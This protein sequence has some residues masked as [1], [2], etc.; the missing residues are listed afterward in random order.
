LFEASGRAGYLAAYHPARAFIVACT[1]RVAK[2]HS[3]VRSEFARLA[4]D[5]P[6]IERRLTSFLA[7]AYNLKV[8]ADYAVGS[9][10]GVSAKEA[11]EAIEGATRFVQAVEKALSGAQ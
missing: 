4:K 8:A 3:G 2:M 9:S 7:R 10:V 11:A 5:N 1:N 6:A